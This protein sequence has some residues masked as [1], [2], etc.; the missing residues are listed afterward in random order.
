MTGCASNIRNGGLSYLNVSS[1]PPDAFC[2]VKRAGTT[3][4]RLTTPGGDSI[5]SSTDDVTLICK[6]D[7][8][9][10]ATAVIHSHLNPALLGNLGFYIFAPVG[11]AADLASGAGYKYPERIDVTLVPVT[12]ANDN[13]K[14]QTNDEC[15]D[16]A[17][18]CNSSGST[19]DFQTTARTRLPEAQ[20]ERQ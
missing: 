10:D 11:V 17:K 18:Q 13:D 4:G 16:C 2:E 14:C 1:S 19:D 20:R 5:T 8:Y 7:G 9:Q 15:A 12:R 6:K 3:I